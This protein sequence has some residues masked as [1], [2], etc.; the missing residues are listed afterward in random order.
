M[1]WWFISLFIGQVEDQCCALNELFL[2]QGF[3]SLHPNESSIVSMIV[4]PLSLIKVPKCRPLDFSTLE[5]QLPLSL[6]ICSC[7]FDY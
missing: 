3:I 7:R 5:F 1:I 6:F 2:L 4:V